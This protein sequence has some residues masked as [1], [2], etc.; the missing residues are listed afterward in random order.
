MKVLRALQPALL[1]MR[2]VELLISQVLC[3]EVGPPAV[4]M[5]TVV[6]SNWVISFSTSRS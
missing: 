3:N 6:P 4:P 1:G 2:G 5:T